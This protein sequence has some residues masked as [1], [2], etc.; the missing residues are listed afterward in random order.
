MGEA[1]DS[2]RSCW[3]PLKTKDRTSGGS[4]ETNRQWEE[5]PS[6]STKKRDGVGTK[7]RGEISEQWL[8]KAKSSGIVGT[9]RL[10][11]IRIQ[12]TGKRCRSI[13]SHTGAA[14]EGI[15][16]PEFSGSKPGAKQENNTNN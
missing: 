1:I 13:V 5:T 7:S 2:G 16:F 3:R 10:A 9:Q 8:W 14:M 11:A 6:L 12:L 4:S 15:L